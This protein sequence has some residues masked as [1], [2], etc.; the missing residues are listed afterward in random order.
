MMPSSSLYL[1][2]IIDF[3]SF[4]N[5]MFYGEREGGKKKYGKF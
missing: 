1:M 3:L 4:F 2:E 5:I